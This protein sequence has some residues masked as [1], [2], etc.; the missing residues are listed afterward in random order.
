MLRCSTG[1]EREH[2]DSQSVPP[3][4]T[5]REFE[6]E[7]FGRGRRALDDVAGSTTRRYAPK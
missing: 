2:G 3:R 7:P 1:G 5:V 6:T 4:G